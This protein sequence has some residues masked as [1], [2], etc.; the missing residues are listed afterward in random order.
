MILEEDLEDLVE[1]A[2][3][4]ARLETTRTS[5]VD[6]I[7]KVPVDANLVVEGNH[8]TTTEEIRRIRAP[9]PSVL[10]SGTP[11]MVSIVLHHVF[12][13][14][15][16]LTMYLGWVVWLPITRSMV[17]LS[18]GLPITRSMVTL[19]TGRTTL[20]RRLT[21]KHHPPPAQEHISP[22]FLIILAMMGVSIL[23]PD[24][25]PFDHGPS[26]AQFSNHLTNSSS[27]Q[28]QL[29]ERLTLSHA[30]VR[31]NDRLL[32]LAMERSHD[33][34]AT[35]R[36]HILDERIQEHVAMLFSDTLPHHGKEEKETEED[37]VYHNGEECDSCEKC[38]SC[39]AA[40][41]IMDKTQCVCDV[42][43]PCTETQPVLP[44]VSPLPLWGSG[45]GCTEPLPSWGS[46]SNCIQEPLPSRGS[47]FGSNQ[48]PQS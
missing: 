43:Q 24:G 42:C 45:L 41:N 30:F 20:I 5:E 22:A 26:G 11:P 13:T 10:R 27:S 34:L 21:S 3:L 19:S 8:Q 16:I 33:Y 36:E 4:Q 18:T 9:N 29:S 31:A 6:R 48:V 14:L 2:E 12:I 28:T 32:R 1:L 38:D 47:D 37:S 46:R 23:Q 7:P 39:E 15:D 35:Q 44:P 17:T 40:P 25:L